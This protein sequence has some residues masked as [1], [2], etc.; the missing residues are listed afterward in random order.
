MRRSLAV[1][2]VL[3][4]AAALMLTGCGPLGGCSLE[5]ELEVDTRDALRTPAGPSEQQPADAAPGGEAQLRADAVELFTNWNTGGVESGAKSPTV[6]LDADTRVAT[7]VTYH[8]N[9]G[10]GATPGTVSLKD[11]ASGKIYG[12]WKCVGSEA[13]GGVANGVWTATPD[14]EL[15]AGRYVVIDSDPASWSQNAESGGLGFAS[16]SG[17][18]PG[19]DL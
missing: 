11:A 3:C 14:A 16:V 9:Y 10:T 15:P 5:R 12:P 18:P 4:V 1:H 13:Q 6:V 19:K 17:T 2:L 7:I 8:F